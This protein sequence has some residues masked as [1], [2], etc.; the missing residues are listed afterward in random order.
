[1]TIANGCKVSSVQTD[2]S[3]RIL[4]PSKQ[5]KT[6]SKQ[7]LKLAAPDVIYANFI[8][9]DYYTMDFVCHV[10][11]VLQKSSIFDLFIIGRFIDD[12]NYHSRHQG[13]NR[14]VPSKLYIRQVAWS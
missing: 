13:N 8:Q 12:Y 1:M 10:F 11:A 7:D 3:N 4:H 14:T 6:K 9:R 2:E 5:L